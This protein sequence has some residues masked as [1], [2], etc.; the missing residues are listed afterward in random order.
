MIDNKDMNNEQLTV[1]KPD[2]WHLHLRDG[3]M[4]EAVLPYSAKQFSR[5]II[6]PNLSQPL[7]NIDLAT[8]YKKSILDALPDDSNFQPLMTL[9]LTDNVDIKQLEQGYMDGIFTAAKLYPAN[10]TTNSSFGVSDIKNIDSAIK[11]MADM[12]M[13]LLIHGE[14]TDKNI[15]IFDREAIFIDKILKPLIDKN[16]NLKIVLEHITTKQA[17]DF[18]K[19]SGD[20]IAATITPHHMMINRSDIFNGGINPHLYCLPIAKRESHRIAVRQAATSGNHKFFLG[21]D[22]APHIIG[23]KE[24]SCGCAGIFNAPSAIEIYT[25]IFAADDMLANLERFISI[26]GAKFYGLPINKDFITIKKQ[27]HI[28]DKIITTRHN[29]KIL[30]FMAGEKINWTIIK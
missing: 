27:D 24:N 9:Y 13:P 10:A 16:S 29:E 15:D 28:I 26:N 18:V 22:S 6:M 1:I 17:V 21:T 4:L 14:V 7:I 11:L 23:N 2:D 25:S 3:L 30:P 12:G 19:Q 8:N 20:N 5:A